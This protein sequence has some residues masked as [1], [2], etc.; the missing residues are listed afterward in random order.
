MASYGIPSKLRQLEKRKKLLGMP[1][2][3]ANG[4]LYRKIIREYFRLVYDSLCYRCGNE[5]LDTDLFHIDHIESW[6]TAEDPRKHF[7]D[8]ENIRISHADCNNFHGYI[9]A[10]RGKRIKSEK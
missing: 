8:L 5:V 4:K 2:G 10:N 9:L 1:W 7:F 3:T 6:L